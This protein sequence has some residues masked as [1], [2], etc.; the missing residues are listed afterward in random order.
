MPKYLVLGA[1]I[2]GLGA[3]KFLK[4][5]EVV[6]SDIKPPTKNLEAKFQALGA[7]VIIGEQSDRLLDGVDFLICSPGIPKHI[8]IINSA[9][10]FKIPILSEIEL[11]LGEFSRPWVAITGTNGKST[12]CSWL[13]QILTRLGFHSPALGN[14]GVSPSEYLAEHA[15]PDFAVVELSSYQLEDSQKLSPSVSCFSSFA[16]DHLDRHGSIEAYMRAKWKVFE[17]NKPGGLQILTNSVLKEAARFG[18]APKSNKTIILEDLA[19]S[20]RIQHGYQHLE[21]LADGFCYQNEKI[22]LSQYGYFF[23]HEIQNLAICMLAA[24]HLTSLTLSEISGSITNLNR[25]NHRFKLIGQFKSQAV[26]NDSKSTNVAAC[27]VALKS[28]ARPCYLLLGGK[29]KQESFEALKEFSNQIEKVLVFGESRDKIAGE[30][31]SLPIEL[32]ETIEQALIAC[33]ELSKLKARAILF[34]PAC[35]SFDQFE[36]FEAR[37]EYF[38]AFFKDHLDKTNS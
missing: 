12:C 31:A 2:S 3:A 35:A 38:E 29:A 21:L 11:S 13:S 32:H 7:S 15:L 34:S 36:N 30:L 4:N 14:I 28:L 6:I 20:Q 22:S 37:G 5:E 8:P 1:G 23:S 16:A 27:Q 17:F 24:H 25:L 33:L 19:C 18:L 26:I 10:K 9:R